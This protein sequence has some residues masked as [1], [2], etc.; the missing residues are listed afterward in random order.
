[1]KPIRPLIYFRVSVILTTGNGDMP[2]AKRILRYT[3]VFE[4]AAEGGYVVRIP[5]L[6]CVTEGDT[7]DE[8]LANLREAVELYLE[9]VDDDLAASPDAEQLDLAV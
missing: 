7:R 3:A 1:M 4:E 8:A 5:T 9:P 6:G 2:R